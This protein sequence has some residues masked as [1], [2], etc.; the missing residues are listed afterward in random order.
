MEEHLGG[1]NKFVMS[2]A[3]TPITYKAGQYF[4]TSGERMMANGG[5]NGFVAVTQ[6]NFAAMLRAI[7]DLELE[8]QRLKGQ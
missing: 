3:A 5:L 2:E 8:V 6:D 4:N 7:A 1:S